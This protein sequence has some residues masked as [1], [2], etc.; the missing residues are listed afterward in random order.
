MDRESDIREDTQ[1]S[2]VDVFGSLGC[3]S[4]SSGFKES[5]LPPSVRRAKVGHFS[6]FRAAGEAEATTDLTA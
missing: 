2:A 3:K 1:L 5:V 6:F 4:A